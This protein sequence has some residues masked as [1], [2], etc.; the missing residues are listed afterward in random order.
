MI[1]GG[2]FADLAVAR[3]LGGEA[4][5]MELVDQHTSPA[6]SAYTKRVL[7]ARGVGALFGLEVEA[8]STAKVTCPKRRSVQKRRWSAPLLMG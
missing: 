6:S 3:R 7:R 4:F 1:V 5:E 8:V 2:G